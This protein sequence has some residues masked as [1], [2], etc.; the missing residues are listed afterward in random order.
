MQFRDLIKY[1]KKTKPFLASMKKIS[2]TLEI[3]TLS[4]CEGNWPTQF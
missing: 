1:S 4:A 3:S 2:E